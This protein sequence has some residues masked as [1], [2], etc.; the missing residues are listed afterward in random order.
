VSGLSDVSDPLSCRVQ[1]HTMAVTSTHRCAGHRTHPHPVQHFFERAA[2][3]TKRDDQWS[4]EGGS[5]VT[6][7][8][9]PAEAAALLG[10]TVDTVRSRIRTGD[11]AVLDVGTPSKPLYRI[12]RSTLDKFITARSNNALGLADLISRPTTLPDFLA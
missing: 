9:S 1:R 10:L 6:S 4:S 12:A 3:E 2:L 5:T 7:T 11:I 8:F